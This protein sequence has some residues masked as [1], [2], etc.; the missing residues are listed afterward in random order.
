VA[1]IE[2]IEVIAG[3]RRR[4]AELAET[5]T[6][7]QLLTRSLCE[8]WSVRDVLAHLLMPLVTSRAAATATIVRARGDLDRANVM[9]TSR[10]AGMSV[11]EI[12]DGLRRHANH[13]FRPPGMSLAAPLTDLLVHTQDMTRPLGLAHRP[14]PEGVAAALSFL[15]RG[16]PRGFVRRGATDGLSLHATDLDRDWGSGKAVSGRGIDLV[17]ALTGRTSALAL[18]EG[19]GVDVLG[20]RLRPS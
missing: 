10:L 13:P 5:L 12:A 18:L 8:A 20:R 15:T 1:D 17:L 9:L 4:V 19:P 2:V 7:E 14:P 16:A 6:E 3:E 11:Q